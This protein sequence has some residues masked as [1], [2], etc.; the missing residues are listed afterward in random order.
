MKVLMICNTDGALYVFRKPIINR[1]VACG[2]EVD[3]ISAASRYFEP[4]NALGVNPLQLDFARHSVSPLSNVRLLR[5]LYAMVRRL[6]PDVVHNFTHKPAI[7]GSI[8]ARL[9]GVKG[10]FITITG[11][12]SLFVHDDP[13][14]RLMRYL[15]LAQYKF[16]LGFV[17]TVF[18]QNPDDMEY[19]V[20]KKL[21]GPGKAVL[22]YGSGLDLDEYRLP[23]TEEIA[24]ARAMLGDELGVDLRGRKVALF[25]ARGVPEKGFFEFYR[26]AKTINALEPD[27]YAFLHL[28]LVDADAA[29]RISKEGI[30][31]YAADCGVKYLGFKDNI[32]DYMIASDI[33]VLPSS[34]REGTPRSLIEALALGK[35]IVTTDMP[36]CR[37]TVIDGWNGYLCRKGDEQSL[38]AKLLAVD[39]E[40]LTAARSRSRR[41]CETKYDAAWLADLTLGRYQGSLNSE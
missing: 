37:E 39:G 40:M 23:A 34:Y 38:V 24:R 18:F 6:K 27:A 25:P 32:K 35:A 22:T 28:G 33:V 16:A 3:S 21:V 1:L 36:G 10:I 29:R 11:L 15:L 20:S 13:K 31:Q 9:A 26:A 2:H 7:F 41:Y 30:E 8:A 17:D 5:A 12:G 4:L 14:T 19:F